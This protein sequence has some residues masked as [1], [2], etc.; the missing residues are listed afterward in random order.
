[1]QGHL[2]AAHAATEAAKSDAKKHTSSHTRLKMGII[3]TISSSHLV[4]YLQA[5]AKR[6]PDLDLDIWESDCADI[7]QALENTEIDIALMSLPD[8][9]DNFRAETLYQEPYLI[10]FAPGHRFEAMNAVPLA[11][12]EGEAYIKRLHCEFPSNF[13]RLGISKPYKNLHVRYSTERED[14]VQLMVSAN[15]GC[16]L[17][18]QYLPMM[19]GI[20]TR[21]LIDPIV[22]RAISV[23]TVAGRRH[24]IP[25]KHALETARS[26]IWENIPAT[27]H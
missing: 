26:I 17:M 23:V 10:A 25:V 4:A 21:P 7:S 6:A 18:P 22:T 16:T 24:S 5:L 8:Y 19:S 15:L 13:L 11:E 1:M 27:A 14:W 9:P 2:S 20:V 3:S 12:L